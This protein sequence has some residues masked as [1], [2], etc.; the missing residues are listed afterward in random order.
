MG[1]NSSSNG[2]ANECLPA[3]ACTVQ[4]EDLSIIVI[5]RLHDCIIDASLCIVELSGV[6]RDSDSKL[7][8]VVIELLINEPVTLCYYS[9]VMHNLWHS[10]KV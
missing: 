10:W 6:G 9:P 2:V 7:F 8:S 1:M 4:K 5:D 3:T